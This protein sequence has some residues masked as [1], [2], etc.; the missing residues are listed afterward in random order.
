MLRLRDDPTLAEFVPSFNS[1]YKPRVL[2]SAR[3][4]STPDGT[5]MKLSWLVHS[6]KIEVRMCL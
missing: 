3:A 1:F 2:P 4:Y 5:F 6:Y